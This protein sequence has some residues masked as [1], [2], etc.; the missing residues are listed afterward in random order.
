[1]V[2]KVIDVSYSQGRIDW[3]TVK[4]H[5]DGAILRCGYGDNISSQD[6]AQWARNVS[7]CERLG[8]PYGVYFYT[9]A[10]TMAHAQSEIAHIQRL[11][12]GRKLSYPV[13]IDIEWTNGNG[14]APKDFNANYI[15]PICE[16]IEKMGFWAGIYASLSYFR[17]TIKGSL[18][19]YT[20]WV[21]QYN[22]TCDMDCDM[23]QYTSTGSVPGI[24]GDVDMNECYQDFPSLI[25]GNK[26]PETKPTNPPQTSEKGDLVLTGDYVNMRA[27]AYVG[28]T[29]IDCLRKGTEV[30]WLADDGW[31]WSKIQCGDKT[32]WMTNEYLSGKNL[33]KYK[34]V[35][36]HGD[37]VNVRRGPGTEYAIIRQL[38]NGNYITCISIDQNGWMYAKINDDYAYVFYDKDYISIR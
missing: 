35:D 14:I 7:E 24:S 27:D 37:Y 19:A 32:G 10:T 4:N 20:K 38:F 15:I 9:Y 1:M 2:K 28:A 26:K 29:V 17:D 16:A 25:L 22:V 33:S 23:W 34:G 11:L 18:D 6:D 13:Y 31:G 8:I 12:K 5:I 36:I 21:A 3:D 30:K